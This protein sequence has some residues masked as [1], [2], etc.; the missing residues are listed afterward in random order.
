[1]VIN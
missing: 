1:M